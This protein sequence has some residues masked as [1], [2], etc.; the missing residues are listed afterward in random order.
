MFT[1]SVVIFAARPLL[2]SNFPSHSSQFSK[3]YIERKHF[4]TKLSAK[5][6]NFKI[7]LLA[8]FESLVEKAIYF[9]LHFHKVKSTILI[10]NKKQT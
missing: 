9:Q 8:I 4:E 6:T 7:K 5:K 2:P 10:I 3:D 1:G